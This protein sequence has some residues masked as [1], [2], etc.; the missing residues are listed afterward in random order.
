MFMVNE[1]TSR[2]MVTAP[3]AL[4]LLGHAWRLHRDPLG[5]LRSL[6]AC[7]DLVKITIGPVAMYVVCHSELV[8][9]MLVDK[10]KDFDKGGPYMDGV[11]TVLGDGLV[12]A[13]GVAHRRQRRLVQPSFSAKRVASY[14]PAMRDQALWAMDSWDAGQ[15]IDLLQTMV[16]LTA[17]VA[18]RCLFSEPG[19]EP[20]PRQGEHGLSGALM[21]AIDGMFRRM[22]NPI[23]GLYSLPLPGNRRYKDAEDKMHRVVYQTIER[24]RKTGSGG[25]LLQTMMDAVDEDGTRFTDQELHDQV[26]TLLLAGTETTALLL[27]WTMHL[28][29]EHPD[30]ER[31]LHEEVDRVLAGRPVQAEDLP[32]MP[33]TRNTIAEVLRLYPPVWVLSRRAE[34]DTSLGGIPVPAGTNLAYSPYLL[35]RDARYFD[36]PDRFDPDRWLTQS[37]NARRGAYLPFGAGSRKCVGDTFGLT[38]AAVVMATIA[39]RWRLRRAPN[40]PPTRSH[41]RMTLSPDQLSMVVSARHPMRSADAAVSTP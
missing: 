38:E 25:G 10:V 16:T 32:S 41:V 15:T 34:V 31:K 19:T 24:H 3:G 7:G 33:Y 23:R 14:V 30:V 21:T 20:P 18:L 11:R 28:L 4:P 12:T 29:E 6:P 2:K 37:T 39:Q 27:A 8:H 40:T 5:L 17:D 9:E 26:I 22:I 36:G 1:S 35:N 13:D